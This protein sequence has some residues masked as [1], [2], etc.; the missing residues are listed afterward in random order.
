MYTL[1]CLVNLCLQNKPLMYMRLIDYHCRLICLGTY[2]GDLL[3]SLLNKWINNDLEEAHPQ[4]GSSSNWNF[5]M[6]VLEERGETGVPGEKPLGARRKNNT[7]H[8][9]NPH[10]ASM[11]GFEPRPHWWE[12]RAITTVP[13]LALPYHLRLY[14]KL[15]CIALFNSLSLSHAPT[16][17]L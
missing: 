5:E 2:G 15:I 3:V 8:K 14:I 17:Q 6:L 12:V 9:L 7:E 10:I 11:R 1:V 13:S 4:S 16:L